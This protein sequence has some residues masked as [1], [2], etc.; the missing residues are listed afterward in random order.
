MFNFSQDWKTSII[1]QFLY[2]RSWI[3]ESYISAQQGVCAFYSSHLSIVSW[4]TWIISRVDIHYQLYPWK[5]LD[6]NTI[7]EKDIGESFYLEILT[8]VTAWLFNTIFPFCFC[9]DH[10]GNTK[11]NCPCFALVHMCSCENSSALYPHMRVHEYIEHHHCTA[12]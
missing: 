10:K 11:M 3:S 7:K 5:P 9:K 8:A 4:I 6:D 12:S 1:I 2:L